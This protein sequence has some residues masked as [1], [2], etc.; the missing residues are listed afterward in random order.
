MKITYL[1]RRSAGRHQVRQ[2]RRKAAR[3]RR[4]NARTDRVLAARDPRRR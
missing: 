1:F 4:V 2:L 3:T